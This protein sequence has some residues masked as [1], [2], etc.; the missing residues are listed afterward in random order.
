MPKNSQIA[1]RASRRIGCNVLSLKDVMRNWLRSSN[2][3]QKLISSLKN[4]GRQ[5]RNPPQHQPTASIETPGSCLLS[6]L[7]LPFW[8]YSVEIANPPNSATSSLRTLLHSH[9]MPNK[10]TG[11]RA[12]LKTVALASGVAA[13][14]TPPP[15]APAPTTPPAPHPPPPVILPRSSMRYTR[16]YTGRQLAMLA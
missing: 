16:V 8:L 15:T 2:L 13:A 9:Q 5:H 6:S 11:R 1:V 12:F 10:T 3:D 7:L 14:Q 4:V